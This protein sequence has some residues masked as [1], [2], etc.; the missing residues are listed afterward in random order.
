MSKRKYISVILPL[1]LEWEP[2]YFV[3]EE[4]GEVSVG[5]RVKVK[6]AHKEY[7]GTVSRIDITPDIAPEKIQPILTVEKGMEKILDQEIALWRMVAQYYLCSTGEVYKAAYPI[8]KINLE[9]S[10]A[11]AKANAA[12]RRKKLLEGMEARIERIREKVARKEEI[13][14]AAKEGTKA[15]L[16]HEEGLQKLKTELDTAIS[17][18]ASA[19]KNAVDME[20]RTDRGKVEWPVSRIVLSDAQQEA[21]KKIKE[22]FSGGKP[23]MLHGVTGSGKTEIYIKLA[24]ETLSKGKSVLYLVPEI[25][26]SRQLEDR[27]KEHLGENLMTFHSGQ[28]AVARRQV[29]EE[30][31]SHQGGKG[32]YIVL[33]TRSSLFL[34]HH[35]LGLIIVDEE[36]DSSYKQDS[37][38]P[39]YNGRDTAL[40]LNL[41]HPGCNIILGSATP[42]LEEQYN[43]HAGRHTLVELKEKFHQGGCTETVIIDTKAERRKNGMIGSVSRKLIA[44]MTET[45]NEGGQILVLRA[46]RAW[47]TSLQC[48]SCGKIEKCPR[49]NVSMTFH[50]NNGTMK[51]HYCGYTQTYSG[52]CSSCGGQL[53]GLG[54]GTQK[55]E[56]ELTALFPDARIARLDSDVAQNKKVEVQTIKDFS[57]G[58]IDILVGTQMITKGFDFSRLRLVAVV[59][60]D[61]FLG[62]EDFR[63]DE[64]ALQVLQQFKGRCGRREEKGVIVI[65]TS[66][67][68]HPIYR[69]LCDGYEA[70]NCELM[71]ERKE[72]GFPPYAR[73]IELTFRDKYKDRAE[74]MASALASELRRLF[75]KGRG[76]LDSPI[77][78][79]YSPVVDRTEDE[80]IRKI[81]VS[82]KKDRMLGSNK[83]AVAEIIS[84]FEKKNK[85]DGHITI[86]VDPS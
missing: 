75:G 79:P 53:K 43:C 72:F 77:T 50:K 35:D 11:A 31:R 28:T 44:H 4:I 49:C 15:R 32:N 64:K 59:S 9:E 39:R 10:R 1:K 6:F 52:N 82:L 80:H 62:M 54:A 8:S 56:E 20:S 14:A 78:G 38:S 84:S 48:E 57:K 61:S 33:G 13:T 24:Q 66:Q 23:V 65:Q 30:I 51:C 5:D 34:P 73:I 55:I 18:Y 76:L 58:E 85:Y 19:V 7:I 42:S 81:R 26:L 37:P 40:M 67:P 25:A 12:E 83:K 3:P 71:Q 45:L 46:R 60:A 29:A 36:H 74:R 22:A 27:L 2:C 63:A 41:T 86:D 21:Y 70:G 47:A 16:K 69:H 68:E 17:A